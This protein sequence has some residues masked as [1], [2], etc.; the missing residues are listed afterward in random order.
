MSTAIRIQSLH[1]QMIVL[2]VLLVLRFVLMAVL[3]SIVKKWR[4]NYGRTRCKTYEG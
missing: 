3:Q 4:N 2:V 1:D